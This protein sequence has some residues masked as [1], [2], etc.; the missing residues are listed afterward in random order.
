MST[1]RRKSAAKMD[2]MIMIFF[3]VHNLSYFEFTM[4]KYALQSKMYIAE[5]YKLYHFSGNI[6]HT[7]DLWIVTIY[8]SLLLW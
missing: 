5:L 3:M 4:L 2:E 8:F 6:Q 1:N 7:D